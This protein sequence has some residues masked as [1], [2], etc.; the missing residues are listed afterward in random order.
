MQ[1]TVESDCLEKR[2]KSLA[3]HLTIRDVGCGSEGP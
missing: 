3:K 2:V 1:M